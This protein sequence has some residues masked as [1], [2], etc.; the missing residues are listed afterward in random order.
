MLKPFALPALALLAAPPSAW[1]AARLTRRYAGASDGPRALALAAGMAVAFAWAAL[2]A[3]PTPILAASLGLGW[4]LV[5]LAA[6]DLSC[7]RLP[8][9]FTLPLLAAGLI[10]AALLP[11]RPI[12]DHLAG[13]AAGWSALAAMAFAYRRWR[14][15]D[16]I[17]EGDAKLLG[18]A[19]AWLGWRA[20]PSVILIACAAAFVWVGFQAIARGRAALGDR[21]AFGAPLCL[22]IWIVWLHGPLAI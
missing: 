6:I 9:A 22:A 18:A 12:P 11:G 5:C 10:V 7:F 2:T 17:G 4:T 3:P 20:L 16:G 13:A 21:L 14:G 19:G 8:D 15:V 1:L